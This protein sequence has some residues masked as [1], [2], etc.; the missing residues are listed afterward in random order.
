MPRRNEVFVNGQAYHIFNK[1]VDRIKIFNN[2]TTCKHT[3]TALWYYLYDHN[4]SLSKFLR[5]KPEIKANFV[6]NLLETSPGLDVLSYTLMPNHFH[7]VVI[8]KKEGAISKY[9]GNLQN[10]L[11]KYYNTRF[12]R[13]GPLFQNQFKAVLIE[14][15]E[16]LLHI[17]RYVIINALTSFVV[18]NYSDLCNYPWS[19]L[20]EYLDNFNSY[21]KITKTDFILNQ[22]PNLDSFESFLSDQVAYQ[23]ELHLIIDLIL[24]EQKH[25][26]Y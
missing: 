2:K 11:A 25:Q 15:D 26:R 3:L 12:E 7:L 19:S 21:M 8:Q 4:Y 10:A 20:P 22:F 1:T 23:R 18:K 5:L 14:T 13:S 6:N 9:V 16:L 24:E 17:V